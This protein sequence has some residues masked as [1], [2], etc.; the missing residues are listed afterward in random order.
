MNELIIDLIVYGF[1]L[2]MLY[3]GI[4]ANASHYFD[5]WYP[6]KYI[7]HKIISYKR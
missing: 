5:P 7:Y 2:Y 4:Y 1:V 6:G 3:L